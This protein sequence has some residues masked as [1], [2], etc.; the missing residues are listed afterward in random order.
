M[1]HILSRGGKYLLGVRSIQSIAA[2]YA[3]CEF[4]KKLSSA[5]DDFLSEGGHEKTRQ[6][7]YQLSRW[8]STISA[9]LVDSGS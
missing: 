3:A 7:F 1:E 4:Q 8:L 6:G 5:H 2:R 9:L